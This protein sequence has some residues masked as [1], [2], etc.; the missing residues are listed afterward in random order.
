M[1]TVSSS[2]RMRVVLCWGP[3]ARAFVLAL[4]LGHLRIA[5]ALPPT[6]LDRKQSL[7]LSCG[8]LDLMPRGAKRPRR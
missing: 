2:S 5:E 3:S 7:M 1:V 4:T 6:P 8:T